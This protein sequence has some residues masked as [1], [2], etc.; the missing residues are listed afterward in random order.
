[1]DTRTRLVAFAG[2]VAVSIALPAVADART[3]SVNLGLPPSAGKQFQRLNVDVDDFFPHGVAINTGD[4][5]RFL[6][7]GFHTFDLPAKGD[8]PL[9]IF[10]PTGETL[11]GANDAAGSP[12]WFNGADQIGFTRVLGRS[13]FGKRLKYDGKKRRT[14]GLPFSESPKPVSVTFTKAGRWT[15]YCN[16]HPGMKGVV[17]VR[18]KGQRVPS[19][20]ADRRRLKN[21]LARSL[22]TAKRLAQSRPPAGVVD[23]GVGGGR[24]EELFAFVPSAITVPAGSTLSFRMSPGSYDFHT[25]TTGP[26]DPERNQNSY[27]GKLLASFDGPAPDPRAV[28]PSEAPATTATLTPT[29]H[30]N[31]FWS[32]GVMDNA[33]AT[34]LPASNS[35]R[36]G[37]AGKYDFYCLIHP[38]M[39]AT[40]TVQ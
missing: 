34:P 25:A 14:S 31:G 36:F 37:A 27:L 1:M 32:T 22:R 19:A 5:V 26:G 8:G 39:K 9:P 15:Y 29:L 3:K 30:G 10:S 18:R 12:F 4:K 33:S 28:Y 17:T 35:V 24:G 40:V 21:Q 2:A 6:P 38:F 20:R 11:A 13:N 7:T 16:L 23:V